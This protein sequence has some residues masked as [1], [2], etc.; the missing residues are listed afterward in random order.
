VRT[1]RK[2]LKIVFVTIFTVLCVVAVEL[3]VTFVYNEIFIVKY[4]MGDYNPQN[5]QGLFKLNW[6]ESYIA[7]YNYGNTLYWNSDFDEA[8]DAY[9]RALSFKPPYDR[10]CAI[11]INIAL[12]ML[13]QIKADDETTSRKSR[14]ENIEKSLEILRTAKEELFKHD[15]G[16]AHREDDQGHSETAEQLKEDI[17]K[18]EQELHKLKD[19]LELSQEREDNGGGDDEEEKIAAWEDQL[20]EIQKGAAEERKDGFDSLKDHYYRGKTW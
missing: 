15:D 6:P 8:I 5:V 3:T 7:H 14:I 2:P 1:L 17:E 19:E 11:R 12:A 18:M 10:E 20:K 16:C 4:R 13:K 9:N